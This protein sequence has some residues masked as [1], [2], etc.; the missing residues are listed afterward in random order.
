MKKLLAGL[1]AGGMLFQTSAFADTLTEVV[2]IMSTQYTSLTMN[3]NAD[4]E[5]NKPMDWLGSIQDYSDNLGYYYDLGD[6]IADY[7]SI[8]ESIMDSSSNMTAK[9]NVSEDYKKVDAEFIGNLNLPLQINEQ[10]KMNN[11]MNFGMWLEMDLSSADNFKY[12]ITLKSPLS[13]KYIHFDLTDMMTEIDSGFL[14]QTLDQNVIN[15]LQKQSKVLLTESLKDSA[16]V[17]KDGSKYTISFDN[18]G[19]IDFL[20]KFITGSM[21]LSKELMIKSGQEIPEEMLN[22]PPE[23]RLAIEHLKQIKLLGE[24]GL[25]IEVDTTLGKISDMKVLFDIDLNLYDIFT[26][27]DAEIPEYITKDNSYISFTTTSDYN[28]KDL[29]NTTVAFPELNEENCHFLPEEEIAYEEYEWTEEEYKEFYSDFPTFNNSINGYCLKGLNTAPYLQFRSVMEEYTAFDF[30]HWGESE[31]RD[32]EI[33]WDNGIVTVINKGIKADFNTIILNSL[34]DEAFVDGEK[35][36]IEPS[37]HKHIVV[38]YDRT[39]ISPELA[40]KMLGITIDNYDISFNS[41]G[42]ALEANVYYNY[43]NP[44]YIPESDEL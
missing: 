14:I 40:N 38:K 37:T 9:A 15:E 20:E 22:L 36:D 17:K 39:F 6:D 28:Y 19:L 21:E 13:R 7:Q 8:V 41:S 35:V 3:F 4:F 44:F 34:T 5:L 27:F 31:Y 29:N 16:E 42:H 18:N 30:Y 26:L 43:P 12:E 25:V 1:L 23:A 24:K 33:K 11:D 10:W 2:D 32:F